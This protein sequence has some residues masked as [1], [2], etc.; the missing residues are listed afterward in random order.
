MGKAPAFQF[1]V[2]DWLSDPEL[3]SAS[4]STRGIWINALC[5][6]WEAKERGILHGTT[7]SLCRILNCT[8]EE[9]DRFLSESQLYAF[10]DLMTQNNGKVTLINRRMQ[11]DERERNLH[12]KRQYRYIERH[13]YSTDDA[14]IDVKVTP[15]SS[16]SS[17]SPTPKNKDKIARSVKTKRAVS[18]A[19]NEF[20]NAL[21]QNPAYRGID[22]D[23][24][25]GKLDA[26]LLTPRGRGKK[27]T[28]QRLVNWLN[29][30]EK[31]MDSVN[32]PPTDPMDRRMWEIE[33]LRRKQDEHS[34]SF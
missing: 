29:K 33:E 9:F 24:E 13:K 16:S 34:K 6:M 30:A 10:D 27:K 21:K 1:Y 12:R 32:N 17:S 23:R 28:Q 8:V 3:Q 31:P 14:K 2:K 22:I 19:D 4:A 26:W 20:I 7:E 11:R 18:M 5:H 25:I 15:P